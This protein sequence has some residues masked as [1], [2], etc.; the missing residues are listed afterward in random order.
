MRR[1]LRQG[2]DQS[3]GVSRTLRR[4]APFGVHLQVEEKPTTDSALLILE[5]P[6]QSS[7]TLLNDTPLCEYLQVEEE[8]TTEIVFLVQEEPITRSARTPLAGR[9][10]T[11]A[12]RHNVQ[13]YKSTSVFTPPLSQR[14]ASW[15][16][17]QRRKHTENTALAT[18]SSPGCFAM[19]IANS[20][21]F[22]QVLGD[23]FFVPRSH[24][25][26]LPKN[27]SYSSLNKSYLVPCILLR[28][29]NESNLNQTSS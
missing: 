28:M 18:C 16:G 24:L 11:H 2:C 13:T 4:V 20:K 6:A 3:A 9:S 23:V 21:T 25:E 12:N 29:Y 26:R 19:S 14:G 10:N 27:K 5:E 7:K 8:R 15:R 1:P 22:P 17:V